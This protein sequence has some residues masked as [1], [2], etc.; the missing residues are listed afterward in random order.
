MPR[1]S[2][3]SAGV[4]VPPNELFRLH[5]GDARQ[6][7][8][9][10]RRFSS[11]REP[12]L[13]CTVT[14]PPYGD[15]KNYG[16]PDQIGWGQPYDE[17]LTELKRVFRMVHRHTRDDGCLWVVIDTLRPRDESSPLWTLEPLPFQ[18]AAELS[19]VGWT[20]RDIIIWKKDKTLPWSSPGRLRNAFEYV[21]F[22]VKSES[23]K[24]HVDRLRETD[25]L[26]QWW[27]KWPERYNPQ[28]KVPPNV[29]EI[30]IPV[31]GQW[32]ATTIQHACP[33]PPDLVERL[34]FLSTDEG[35][36]VFDPFAGSGVVLAEAARLG[37]RPIGIELVKKSVDAYE[38]VV[39]PE[40]MQRRG[41][42]RLAEQEEHNAWLRRTILELRVL[43]YTRQ[44]VEGAAR[45]RIDLPRP[46]FT[47][48][49]SDAKR[50]SQNGKL[51][52]AEI[53]VVM[54]GTKSQRAEL[55][56]A[57]IAAGQRKPTSMFGVGAH[58]SVVS[59][60]E[61][62]TLTRKT[63]HAYVNGKHYMTAGKVHVDDLLTYAKERRGDR[64]PPILSNILLEQVPRPI[65]APNGHG[66]TVGTAKEPKPVEKTRRPR[67]A[68]AQGR[69]RPSS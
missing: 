2:Q 45:A 33:L 53:T 15:L 20:L 35:D 11:E 49:V 67:T 14:S 32:S 27:V 62:P 44:I 31:Q 30:P 23:F 41:R 16:H 26:E 68:K 50:A 58:V 7:D 37:R 18:L 17:Y 59:R 40:I 48:V 25:R 6:L 4:E 19:T 64:I 60:N 51:V 42:D 34:L 38:K 46:L 69:Q 5:C 65:E 54:G 8:H 55:R 3:Q 36:I 47:L 52:N 39:R 28:G 66:P 22:F 57:L 63:L 21:L 1:R 10:L 13:T 9:L 43:K 24:Y 29:W 61:I 56:D 12:L